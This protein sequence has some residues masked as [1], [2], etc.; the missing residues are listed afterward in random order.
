[1]ADLES[2]IVAES[3]HFL[4]HVDELLKISL[5]LLALVRRQHAHLQSFIRTVSTGIHG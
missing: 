4:H 5:S 2:D 3:H 1:M